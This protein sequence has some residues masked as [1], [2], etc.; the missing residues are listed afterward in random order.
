MHGLF[1]ARNAAMAALA[2]ALSCGCE[3]PMGFDLGALARFSGVRRRQ[4]VLYEDAKWTV[5]E[6]FAHHPTAIAGALEGLRAAYPNRELI[7]SFEPRSN[8]ARTSLFQDAFTQALSA[9]DRIYL[10][11]VHRAE[12]MEVDKRLDTLR[13]VGELSRDG[14]VAIAFEANEA[15]FEQIKADRSTR[16]GGV[17]VFFT[18]GSF[19]GVPQKTVEFLSD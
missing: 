12:M 10:G 17:F 2:A 4:D 11:A 8:T 15:L 18:N 9:A 14:R 1:N 16:M 6:D 3:S 7:V 5:L 13:M 19:D